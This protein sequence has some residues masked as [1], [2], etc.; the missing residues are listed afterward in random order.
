MYL[1]LENA[2]TCG[3]EDLTMKKMGNTV[4]LGDSYSTFL[5]S[6]PHGYAYWYSESIH[7]DHLV[8]SPA[9]TWW[10]Q[11]IERTDS[12]L[13]LNCSWS[14]TTICHTGWGAQD[15]SEK[16]FATR[17]DN[18]IDADYFAKNEINTLL[19]FGAT[20]DSWSG[21]PFGEEKYDNITRE[22]MFSFRPALAHMLRRASELS[23][24]RVIYIVNTGLKPEFT[25]AIVTTCRRYGCEFVL[26][27]EVDKLDGHPTARGMTEIADAVEQYLKNA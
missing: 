22:D 18:L 23:G 19:I 13:V 9:D 8:N 7:P 5:G 24:V 1:I 25:D 16:S 11:L 14:G 10:Y 21:A 2:A 6:V 15:C 20:N 12:K 27:P 17:L 26:L 3:T 4:I